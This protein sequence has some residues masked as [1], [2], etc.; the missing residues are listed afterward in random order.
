M[1]IPHNL[2]KM[3]QHIIS[4]GGKPFVVG[5]AVRDHLMGLEPKDFDVEVFGMSFADLSKA[6]ESFGKPNMVGASFGIINIRVDGES[7][8]F[9]IPRRENRIGVGHKDFMVQVDPSMTVEDAAARRDFTIN[10][11]SFDVANGVIVDPFNGKDAL[12]AGFLIPTSNAFAEDALRVL[13]GMQFAA[14]FELEAT[15]GCIVACS[16]MLPDFKALPKERIWGEWEKWA[17]KGVNP[18]LGLWFLGRVGWFDAF[19]EIGALHGVLQDPEWHPEGDAFRHTG[20]VCNAAADIASRDNLNDFDRLVL[21]FAAL[22][23]DFGKATCTIV[24][25]GRIRSPGHAQ[26]GM[27]IADKFLQ[28]IGCPNAIREQVIPLVGE[29]MAHIGMEVNKRNLR[30]LSLR[31]GPANI[32]QL[33]RV[34]EADMSGRPPK[35]KGLPA[36]CEAIREM[37]KDLSIDKGGPEA[38]VMGRHLIGIGIKPGPEMGLILKEC[39]E[40][41]MEGVF[42]SL[43]G[44]LNW[45]AS[46]K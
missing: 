23:H 39:F 20:L 8:D 37:A 22:C 43:E 16:K 46:K 18:H 30:R 27:P 25:D 40:A 7:F 5:G 38:I 36:E 34:I 29:H 13:R 32:E 24:K 33:L 12:E 15:F 31:L 42:D 10:A 3:C 21:M 1:N 2:N 14:R 4:S 17:L 41:Q 44:G 28:S 11:I 35:P 9:S 6:L 19:P 26:E 45:I